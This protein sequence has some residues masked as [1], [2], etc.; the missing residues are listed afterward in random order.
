MAVYL[1][2]VNCE[3]N[4]VRIVS[5]TKKAAH[6]LGQRKFP[7]QAVQVYSEAELN[8]ARVVEREA[9]NVKQWMGLLRSMVDEF[10][11]TVLARRRIAAA[12]LCLDVLDT[13]FG[14]EL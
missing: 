4:P 5:E 13:H 14:K 6:E 11:D 8:T 12:K 10:T 1:I 3:S 7:G 9:T 2:F